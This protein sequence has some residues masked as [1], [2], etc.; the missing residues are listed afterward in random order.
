M[1]LH[2]RVTLRAGPADESGSGPVDQLRAE[3]DAGPSQCAQKA[4][5][6]DI[7]DHWVCELND[8]QRAVVERRFG[9]H[10]YRR[11]TLE[12]IGSEIGVT[13]ERVRQIQLDA[14]KNLRSM[15]EKDGISG[16]A[17]LD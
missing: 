3:R 5:V 1:G 6:N 17:I 13:R 4:V 9:L 12:Q 15:M 10:G 2:Q 7:V 11:A 16:D 8:K 14:L